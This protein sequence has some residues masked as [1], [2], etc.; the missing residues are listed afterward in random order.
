MPKRLSVYALPAVVRPEELAGGAVVVIDVLRASTT[1]IHALETGAREVVP[2]LDVEEAREF[3]RA[4]P[5]HD[6]ILGGERRGLPIPGFHLGNS[7]EDY[8]RDRVAGKAIAFTTTNGTRAILHARQ[9]DRV[10][11]GAFVNAGAVVAELLGEE[12]I[13]LLCAGT[14]GQVSEDD[15]LLAGMLVDRMQRQLG[16][17][18][19]LNAQAVTA[20]EVWSQAFAV[21]QALGAEP[22]PPERLAA[23]L[24][25]SLGGKDL[26]AVGLEDDILAASHIDKFPNVPA[27]DRASMRIRLL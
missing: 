25:R 1:I 5:G 4:T 17:S 10:L 21:P 7:P 6:V 16:D 3:A 9:A 8:T 11:I 24:R 12:S 13:H 27:V 18:V 15:V 20:R 2:F 19:E 22:I 14:G 23:R 26:V